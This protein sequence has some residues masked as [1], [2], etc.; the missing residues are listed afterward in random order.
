MGVTMDAADRLLRREGPGRKRQE[1]S[2]P[3][4]RMK[5]LVLAFVAGTALM[6][7]SSVF[8]FSPLSL[9]TRF[10][11][12][13]CYPLLLLISNLFLDLF[14]PIFS[15]LG[16][17]GLAYAYMKVPRFDANLFT[18]F[19]VCS[20]LLLGLIRPRF[21]CRNLCP[22]GALLA[23]CSKRPLLH[24]RVSHACT[25]CGRCAWI[26]PM[27]AVV[28]DFKTTAHSECIV[29]LKCAE[30]CPEKAISFGSGGRGAAVPPTVDTSR[31]AFLGSGA[32]GMAVAAV[33][34]TNLHHL[35]GGDNPPALLSARLIRPPGA[36]PEPD[37]QA[38]C[39]RCGE[40]IKGCLTN[41]LQPIWFEAGLSGLWTPAITARLAG[42]EQNCNVCGHLCPTGAIRPLSIEEKPFA[43]LGTAR[44]VASR[45]I[46][47]EQDKKCLIC[48]EICPYN[49]I[50][51]LFKPGHSVTVPVIDEA[52]CNG[53]GYCENKCPVEGR[54]AVVVEPLG[55]LR[56]GKGSYR[57][58]ARKRGL[59]FHARAPEEDHVLLKVPQDV[60]SEEAME[61]AEEK[62][63]ELPP[64]FI[65]DD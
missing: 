37:F 4:R 61:P 30:V 59:I 53:C 48:D 45:C 19:L 8:L 54:A 1:T 26:C 57:E 64:G 24:R 11:G 39:V 17:E 6:G 10:Y 62:Q 35:H 34:M 3:Y 9:I 31:R 44:I 32:A 20:L 12:L 22:A 51:S 60:V 55:Q 46:A 2:H 38:C 47:W 33:T 40:C 56:L 7:I 23:L 21:W 29:C 28:A 63:P 43:K 5:L 41:T 49:A 13:V 50:S 65:L 14:R 27:G 36:L 25:A 52:R 18:A 58:E 42:C 16:L 15:L